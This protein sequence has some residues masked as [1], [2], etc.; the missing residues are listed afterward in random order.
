MGS[1]VAETLRATAT[2]LDRL[3]LRWYVFGAQ[4]ALLRGA[5]AIGRA[6]S[7]DLDVVDELTLALAEA[8]GEHEILA[9]W[10]ALRRRL[11]SK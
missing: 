5:E 7:M 2:G 11:R 8:I 10:Q 6:N 3:G 4:A 1:P 9:H